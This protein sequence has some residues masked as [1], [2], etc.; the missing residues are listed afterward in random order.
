MRVVFH[1]QEQRFD[2]TMSTNLVQAS[3]EAVNRGK[4]MVVIACLS[5]SCLR[6]G[7]GT[8]FQVESISARQ[9]TMEYFCSLDWRLWRHK[10][11]NMMSLTFV[12]IF[13]Q[14]YAMFYKPSTTPIYTTPNLSTLHW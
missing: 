9:N 7:G 4:S 5:W 14:F 3:T 12:S 10:H 13:K 6:S 2:F 1:H 11:W 8:F